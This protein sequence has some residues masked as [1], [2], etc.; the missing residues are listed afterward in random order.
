MGLR[1]VSPHQ[2]SVWRQVLVP[3]MGLATAA[4]VVI[5]VALALGGAEVRYGDDALVLRLG[6]PAGPTAGA[7]GQPEAAT[8]WQTALV[9][10]ENELRRDLAA[11][12]SSDRDQPVGGAV[13]RSA[14]LDQVRTLISESE[15]RLQRE[16]ALWLTE[17]AQELDMQ[18]RADQ[19][20]LQ[21]ELGALEGYADYLVRVS[22]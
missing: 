7:P 16:R 13:D 19:Q 2:P 18:R 17:F 14:L 4:G 1:I 6:R 11:A 12:V 15:R 10:L 3:A 21:Q 22:R 20:Q 5:G 9:A 8:G